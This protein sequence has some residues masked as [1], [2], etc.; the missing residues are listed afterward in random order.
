[1]EPGKLTFK[2]IDHVVELYDVV[3][4]KNTDIIS[5]FYRIP[6]SEKPMSARMGKVRE[7]FLIDLYCQKRQN[8]GGG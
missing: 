7:L 3:G 6:V 5:Y 8:I 1:M 2:H 4:K